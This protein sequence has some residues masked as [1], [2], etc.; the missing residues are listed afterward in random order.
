MVD[1]DH[2]VTGLRTGEEIDVRIESVAHGGSCVARHEGRVVFVRGTIPGERVIARITDAPGHGR[3]ARA[4]AVRIIEPSTDRV[5]PPCRYTGACGGCDWQH[6]RLER[7]REFKAAVVREQLERL[8]REPLDRWRDLEVRA[9]PG[10]DQGLGWRTRMR[11]SVDAEGRAGLHA[12][13]SHEIVPI[14]QCLLAA[15]AIA[16]LG[17]TSRPWT[18]ADEVLAV[19]TS[20][21]DQVVLADPRPGEAWVTESAAHREW[22]LDATAFWQVHP[23]A[24]DALVGS[25]RRGLS[26]RAGEHVIDLYSGVGLF[27]GALASDVG[28]G[29]RIDAVE[30]DS[31]AARSARR[32]LHDCPTVVLHQAEAGRWLRERSVTRCDLVVLDP[33]RSGAGRNVMADLIALGPRAVAYVACDPAALARDIATAKEHGWRLQSLE[34]WDLFPMTHHVECVAVLSPDGRAPIASGHADG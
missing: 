21:G 25:V 33:P 34:C 11:Y 13:H 17:V 27:A 30:A 15:P 26:P 16:G 29:G 2:V 5:D 31:A 20:E 3:F 6:V 24:P 1:Q 4:L 28:A 7:Q 8:A 18:G 23:G 14:E 22:R 12:Y 32:S 19:S 9:V 10:D